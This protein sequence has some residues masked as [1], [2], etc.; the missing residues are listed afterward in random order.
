MQLVQPA[1]QR[2]LASFHLDFRAP[3]FCQPDQS[4]GIMVELDGRSGSDHLENLQRVILFVHHIDL[5]F[6]KDQVG[7]LLGCAQALGQESLDLQPGVEVEPDDGAVVELN[8][9]T[10]FSRGLDSVSGT[11]GKVEDRNLRSE[12]PLPKDHRVSAV[13]LEVGV[14]DMAVIEILLPV[15]KLVVGG[16][17][18]DGDRKA[19][20][21]R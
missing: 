21:S 3:L 13:V 20:P 9:G 5:P 8:L 18:G 19:Q 1:E 15:D 12:A 10:P 2:G 16:G 4:D 14:A 17:A 11:K 6:F 7:N